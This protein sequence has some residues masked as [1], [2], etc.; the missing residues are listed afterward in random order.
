MCL[1]EQAPILPDFQG[2]GPGD[3]S[4]SAFSSQGPEYTFLP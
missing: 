1:E 3:N 4:N 2:I